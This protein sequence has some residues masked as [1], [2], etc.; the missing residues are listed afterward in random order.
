[1]CVADDLL[2]CF[3]LLSFFFDVK[4]TGRI[5]IQKLISFFFGDSN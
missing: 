2:F 3:F 5:F 4:E 1:M